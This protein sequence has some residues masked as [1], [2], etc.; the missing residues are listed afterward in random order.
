MILITGASAGIG[1]A[2]AEQFAKEGKDLILVARR[3]DRLQALAKRLSSTY[4]VSVHPFAIDVCDKTKVAD[5]SKQQSALLEKVSVLIN[6]AGLSKGLALF[7]DGSPEDWEVTLDTNVKGLLY[8]T[9]ALIPF[10]LAK[11][12]GHIVNLGS[13]AG[14]A[15]YPRGNVYC[16][17]KAAVSF[18]SESLRWDLNGKGIRVTEI[19]PGMVHTEFSLVRFDGD[20]KRAD[21]VYDGFTPLTAQDIAEA[22]SWSVNRPKHVNISELVIYPTA[23]ASTTLT[24]R[25]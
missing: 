4:Q 17:S 12:D 2:C 16:A 10:F 15:V 8:F 13:V 1:E 21:A 23:Q 14:R 3:L 18:L 9:H 20:K 6:N 22:I 5:F 11:R 24:H 25:E 7:Q 19:A